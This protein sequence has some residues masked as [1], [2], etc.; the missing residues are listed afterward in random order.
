MTGRPYVLTRSAAA[1][2]AE[3]ARYTAARWGAEQARRYVAQL[4]EA[5]CDVATGQG[6]LRS[7]D[8][9]HPGLRMKAV[10]RHF[11]FCLPQPQGP[12]AILAVLHERM[13]LMVRLRARLLTGD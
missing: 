4:E 13:D 2:V 9:I 12:A 10:G 6:P 11:I 5:A 8:D 7:L 1:D 3:I